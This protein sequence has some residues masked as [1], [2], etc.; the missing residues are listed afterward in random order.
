[1]LQKET[2]AIKINRNFISTNIYVHF[3]KD[4]VCIKCTF[5]SLLRSAQQLSAI[6]WGKRL[7]SIHRGK[8]GESFDGKSRVTVIIAYADGYDIISKNNIVTN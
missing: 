7:L 3:N 6:F 1:M 5:K 2:F 4:Y 8:L